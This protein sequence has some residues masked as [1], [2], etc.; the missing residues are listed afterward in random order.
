M[1]PHNSGEGNN[2]NN[3]VKRNAWRS[4]RRDQESQDELRDRRARERAEAAASEG[5]RERSEE[6]ATRGIGGTDTRQPFAVKLTPTTTP[7]E[8]QSSQACTTLHREAN[9]EKVTSKATFWNQIHQSE[10]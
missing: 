3:I 10:V 9:R 7:Q 8:E 6:N 1:N 5:A 2:N 4:T